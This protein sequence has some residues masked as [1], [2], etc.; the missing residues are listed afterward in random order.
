MAPPLKTQA[1]PSLIAES[2]QICLDSFHHAFSTLQDPLALEMAQN[3]LIRFNLW[4]TNIAALSFTRSSLDFRLQSSPDIRSMV[5]QLL[6][7]LQ[8]NLQ[9]CMFSCPNYARL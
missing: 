3:Q 2:S 4:A 7:I 5:L 8:L 9:R 1:A 6:S